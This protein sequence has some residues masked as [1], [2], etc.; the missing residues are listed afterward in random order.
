MSVSQ[1]CRESQINFNYTPSPNNIVQK[2][3]TI[4]KHIFKAL[5]SEVVADPNRRVEAHSFRIQYCIIQIQK[6]AYLT[7]VA[8]HHVLERVKPNVHAGTSDLPLPA[9]NQCESLSLLVSLI[10]SGFNTRRRTPKS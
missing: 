4:Q 8:G 9:P 5:L 10:H 1:Y 2:Y 7:E 3:T 6:D